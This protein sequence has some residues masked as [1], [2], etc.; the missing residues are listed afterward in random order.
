MNKFRYFEVSFDNFEGDCISCDIC[1]L[2]D[3]VSKFTHTP[4]AQLT[5]ADYDYYIRFFFRLY[6]PDDEFIALIP[7]IDSDYDSS[8]ALSWSQFFL[9]PKSWY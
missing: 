9:K 2:P 1:L 6:R 8:K 7:I 5:V 3:T 4:E